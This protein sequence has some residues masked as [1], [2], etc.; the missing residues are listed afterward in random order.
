MPKR[1]YDFIEGRYYHVLNKSIGALD[2]FP[3][4]TDFEYFEN[5]LKDL[6]QITSLGKIRTRRSRNKNYQ[7][8][9][10]EEPLVDIIA[11]NLLGDHFHLIIKESTSEGITRFM[12]KLSTSYAKYY[13][14]KYTRR[15]PLFQ[16]KFVANELEGT[17]KLCEGTVYV[18]MNHIHHNSKKH[19][20]S[21]IYEYI[22]Q[23]QE[24]LCSKDEIT[25]I[26]KHIEPETYLDYVKRSAEDLFRNTEL[27]SI[28]ENTA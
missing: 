14:N 12:H 27:E 11:Y 13:N 17:N 3:E 26:H 28:M 1:K 8:T 4:R 25:K 5:R 19:S 2:I 6:N 23:E 9:T 16:G 7:A 20:Y 24:Y 22:S 15:G 18:N 21:S 10:N